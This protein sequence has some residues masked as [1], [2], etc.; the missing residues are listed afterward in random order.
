MLKRKTIIG[1][2][3]LILLLTSIVPITSSYE[4][5]TNKILYVDD[6]N[7]MGPWDGTQKHP[8]QHIQDGIDAANP[9]DTVFVFSGVYFERVTINKDKIKLIGEDR[10]TTTIDNNGN[11]LEVLRVAT[12]TDVHIDSFE[13]RSTT[14][15][16]DPGIKVLS[17]IRTNITNCKVHRTYEGIYL[18]DAP[19]T[20]IINCLVYDNEADSTQWGN[21]IRLQN[22]DNT[23]IKDCMCWNNR[24]TAT[25]L[26][27]GIDFESSTSGVTII[28][29]TCYDNQDDGISIDSDNNT[30]INSTCYGNGGA[31][32]FTHT[33]NDNKI[34]NC[35][36]YDNSYG[37]YL[38]RSAFNNISGSSIADNKQV[39]V[40]LRLWCNENKIHFNN[41]IN[42]TKDAFFSLSLFNTWNQNYW[43][44]TRILPKPIFGIMGIIPWVNF[45]WHPAQEPYEIKGG[46]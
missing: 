33:S 30:I 25:S 41:F 15:Y 34:I 14:T 10:D 42:N 5:S 39:G 18:E 11:G 29:C 27:D 26:G 12:T 22:S 4:V 36:L 13:I 24:E 9:G 45:D 21:G 16:E 3:I 43:G 35:H 1:G 32:I 20:R 44:K 8:Y 38:F 17:A 31:G 28:N 2:I 37:I 40:Y 7:T 6:D 46:N 23:L 19:W